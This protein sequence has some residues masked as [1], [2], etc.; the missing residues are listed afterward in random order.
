MKWLRNGAVLGIVP[1]T[2]VYVLPYVMG[3]SAGAVHE[4]GG[5]VPAADSAHL[6]YAIVR[7]RLMDVDVIFQQGYVYT[8]A[9]VAVLGV[10][11]AAV[12]HDRQGGGPE[13]KRDRGADPGLD[14]RLPADPQLDSGAAR[15][16]HFYRDRYDYRRT[17]VEFARE[18]SSETDLDHMLESVGER[19]IRTLSIRYVAVFPA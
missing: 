4:V 15:P 10:F 17:L 11:Y 16:L 12:L 1:F 13:P 19:L 3:I 7:Y 5:A 8:L 6:G 2:A 14:V 9:T 18:L